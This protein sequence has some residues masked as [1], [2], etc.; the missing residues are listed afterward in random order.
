MS[1]SP[2]PPPP[3]PSEGAP[4]AKPSTYLAWSIL[5][6]IFCCLP[7]GIVAIVKSTQVDS[8]WNMGQYAAAQNASDAA[9]K[10][11]IVAAVV[12]VVLAVVSG[13]GYA[14]MGEQLVQ[15]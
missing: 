4:G 12:G 15:Y 3:T 10:W 13:I 6:T 11:V 2:P 1:Y 9:K 8:L 5:A 14:L 7:F